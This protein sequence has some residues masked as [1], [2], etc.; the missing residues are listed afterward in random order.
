MKKTF[1]AVLLAAVLL[2]NTFTAAFA[3]ELPK[4]KV[5]DSG[6]SGDIKWTLT[7]DNVLYLEGSGEF[8]HSD[9]GTF[10]YDGSGEEYF[11]TPCIADWSE[12][13][14]RIKRIEVNISDC[15]SLYGLFEGETISNT[16]SGCDALHHKV[17]S[18]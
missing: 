12:Y 7:D 8:A 9:I 18:F 1:F 13:N 16:K 4:G 6:Y 14:E 3:A 17:P 5:V 10:H 15:T 11:C 2:A